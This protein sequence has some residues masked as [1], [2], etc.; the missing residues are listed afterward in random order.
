MSKTSKLK[1]LVAVAVVASAATFSSPTQ[2]SAAVET[3]SRA[4]HAIVRTKHSSNGIAA[5]SGTVS[6]ISGN[7][8]TLTAQNG[9]TYSVDASAAKIVKN[10]TSATLSEVVAGDTLVVRGTVSGN[11]VTA[12]AIFDGQFQKVWSAIKSFAHD[13]FIGS[14]SSVNGSSFTISSQGRKL[15]TSY[16][17]NTDGTTVIKKDGQNASLSDIVSGVKVRVTGTLASSTNTVTAKEVTIVTLHR[18]TSIEGSVTAISGNTLTVSNATSTYSIDVSRAKIFGSNNVKSSVSS[19]TTGDALT[20]F[21]GQGEG[22]STINAKIV[23]D[24]SKAF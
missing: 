2:V 6:G 10:K 24:T 13:R 15:S 21:G 7:T 3:V 1:A 9:T 18:S 20:I 16:T 23:R 17:V 8:I 22:S 19:I 12:T 5:V 4:H 14:V 11:N